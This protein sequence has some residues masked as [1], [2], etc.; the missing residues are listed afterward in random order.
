M[1]KIYEKRTVQMAN[2]SSQPRCTQAHLCVSVMSCS[3]VRGEK[4]GVWGGETIRCTRMRGH[5]REDVSPHL[6]AVDAGGEELG[7]VRVEEV[8]ETHH[9]GVLGP[10]QLVVLVVVALVSRC[11]IGQ[12]RLGRKGRWKA[13]GRKTVP[14]VFPQQSPN[15]SH[16]TD[17][18]EV[19]ER[20]ARV[21]QQEHT[22]TQNQP[23]PSTDQQ[24]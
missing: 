23:P 22:Q 18:A 7:R 11:W 15:K 16:P 6:V 5:T 12:C 24:Q 2:S 10:P 1:H 21:T 14:T 4:D 8:V 9:G 17:L 3:L 13:M 19:E 20:G